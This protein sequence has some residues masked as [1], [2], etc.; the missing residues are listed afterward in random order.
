MTVSNGQNNPNITY[1]INET[2]TGIMKMSDNLNKSNTTNIKWYYYYYY[3]YLKNNKSYCSDYNKIR[4]YIIA[5][6]S[7]VPK[8]FRDL[9]RGLQESFKK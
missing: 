6:I 2:E 3:K 8:H 1:S 5:V 7:K 4:N 9:F